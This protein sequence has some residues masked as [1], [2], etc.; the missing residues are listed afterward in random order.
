MEAKHRDG[1]D[2]GEIRS[3]TQKLVNAK[4]EGVGNKDI[5][6][7]LG[8]F[9][10][11]LINNEITHELEVN[12]KPITDAIHAEMLSKLRVYGSTE[13]IKILENIAW[14]DIALKSVPEHY[15]YNPILDYF[16]KARAKFQT[17][18]LEN[19]P[20]YSPIRTLSRLIKID[21]PEKAID[22]SVDW[23]HDCLL[24]WLM[25]AVNRVLV[26]QQNW[27][28]VLQGK[29]GVGK[30]LFANKIGKVA[31]ENYFTSGCI[32]PSDPNHLVKRSNTFIWEA[33]E[34]D[35]TMNYADMGRLKAF[36]T[37]DNAKERIPY[38]KHHTKHKAICSFIGTVNNSEFLRDAT[39]NRRYLCL[40]VLDMHREMILRMDMDLVW[41]EAIYELR[42]R[43]PEGGHLELPE[44]MKRIQEATNERARIESALDAVMS[45]NVVAADTGG[46]TKQEVMKLL[47]DNHIFTSLYPAAKQILKEKGFKE[48]TFSRKVLP[49]FNGNDNI[50]EN[51][52][53]KRG[54]MKCKIV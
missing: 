1:K 11:N 39:G 48:G 49:N 17:A 53:T 6:D 10:Y 54:F 50:K 45:E 34:L 36:L 32:N 52:V 43:C 28:L 24:W 37:D 9:G 16:S 51:W 19:G 30:S 21:I 26:G 40:E 15:S 29:Q 25:G 41:G 8:R 5:I 22:E 18:A 3:L 23:M 35:G 38:D 2:Q 33:G 47:Q 20:E 12:G 42:M 14:M 46:I 31:G 4:G 7:L 13:K 44:T 27:M